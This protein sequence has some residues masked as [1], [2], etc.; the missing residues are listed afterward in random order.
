MTEEYHDY[1]KDQKPVN[2]LKSP[3]IKPIEILELDSPMLCSWSVGSFS[4]LF[5]RK[6]INFIDK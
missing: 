1:I 5:S 3:I 6:D 2:L 4:F